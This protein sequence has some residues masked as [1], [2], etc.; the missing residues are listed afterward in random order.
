MLSPQKL[1]IPLAGTALEYQELLRAGFQMRLAICQQLIEHEA[2]VYM[3]AIFFSAFQFS[4]SW[5]NRYG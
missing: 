5:D 1:Q 2:Q 3:T 4:N